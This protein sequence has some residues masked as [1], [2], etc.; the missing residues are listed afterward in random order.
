MKKLFPKP[1]K[2]GK[3]KKNCAKTNVWVKLDF[4]QIKHEKYFIIF[5]TPLWI[6]QG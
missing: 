5:I 2:T 6:I 4:P 1:R 3:V